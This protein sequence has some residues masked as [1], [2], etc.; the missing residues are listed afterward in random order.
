MIIGNLEK[1]IIKSKKIYMM[2]GPIKNVGF[3]KDIQEELKKDLRN[4]HKI[5]FIASSPDNHEETLKY[6]YG[7]SSIIGI[8][9]YLN[10]IIPLNDVVVNIVDNKN[11]EL[12]LTSD[13]I[14]L[15][16]G[17][18]KTQL[19]FLK[20]NN[21]FEKLQ[22]YKGILLGT[23]CG[24]MNIAKKGY[25]SKDKEINES[26]FYEGLALVDITID[27]HFDIN[28]KNQVNEIKKMSIDN[29]IYGV[30]DFSSIIIENNK[31]KYIGKIYLVKDG[32]IKEYN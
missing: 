13:V 27:P 22:E 23:S 30:S 7:N 18:Y 26:F 11:K 17:N 15:L 16:G 28:N 19:A 31:L 14:Y 4:I 2:S 20:E 8:L 32:I 25:Y 10:M 5:S 24:A 12:D 21:Y 9:D 29:I 6:V 3:S 1:N